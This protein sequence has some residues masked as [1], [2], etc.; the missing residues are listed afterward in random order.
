MNMK[1]W[2]RGAGRK[3]FFFARN[4]LVIICITLLLA[5]VAL[6]ALGL[7]RVV[8]YEP[9]AVTGWLGRPGAEGVYDDEGYAKIR[10]SSAGVRDQERAIRKPAEVWRVAVLG[11]SYTDAL[12]VA[13]DARFTAVM[14]RLL[15][16]CDAGR[17]RRVEVL[18]FGVSGY[19]T[20]QEYLL[21]KHHVLPYTPDLVVLAFLPGNDVVDNVRALDA[22][23]SRPYAALD[24]RG[25]LIWDNS[26]ARSPSF[27][28][29]SGDFYRAL[30]RVSDYSRV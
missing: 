18:N 14:E 27:R 29:K 15:T 28:F 25:E 10:I 12:Q 19:G 22:S 6:R 11:D 1:G 3:M 8:L 16:R 13:E 7:S 21:L 23:S 17:G 30:L 26:F 5:E 24:E 20:V 2:N 9:H 4:A